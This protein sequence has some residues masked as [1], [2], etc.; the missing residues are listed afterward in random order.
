MTAVAVTARRIVEE[1]EAAGVDPLVVLNV[2][3]GLGSIATAVKDLPVA[4]MMPGY[5]F[6]EGI[7]GELDSV[8]RDKVLDLIDP[9]RP[10]A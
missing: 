2:R 7:G 8:R 6:A 4:G 5:R 1:L 3:S 10:D 9:D